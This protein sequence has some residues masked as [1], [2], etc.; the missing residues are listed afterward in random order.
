[1]VQ[2]RRGLS[3][4]P[5]LEQRVAELNGITTQEIIFF[6]VVWAVAFMATVFRSIRDRDS[7]SFWHCLAFGFTA[8][9]L[10]SGIIAVLVGRTPAGVGVTPWYWI[11]VSA[12]IGL[13]GKEQDKVLR[14]VLYSLLKGFRTALDDTE[15]KQ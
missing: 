3:F 9:F 6:A 11:G 12:L 14:F 15:K 7:H 13:L 2:L 8:G 10:A 5:I 1:M 4:C